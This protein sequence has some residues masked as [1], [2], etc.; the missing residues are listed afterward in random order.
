MAKDEKA[1]A[2]KPSGLLGAV[3]FGSILDIVDSA[4]AMVLRY[5]SAHYR[6]D[7]RVENLKEDAKKKVEEIRREAIETGY[8]IKKAIFRTIVEGVLLT[9]GLL[10]L[11][12][13]LM[14]VVSDV[15]PIKWVLLGYGLIV[16]TFIVFQLKTHK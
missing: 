4:G 16:T 12:I 2:G 5:L 11:I 6:V 3:P 7:E 8:A 1:K 14:L 10:A 13:G 9:T 15:V